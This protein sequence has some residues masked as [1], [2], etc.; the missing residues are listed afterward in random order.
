MKEQPPKMIRRIIHFVLMLFINSILLIFKKINVTF[1]FLSKRN[2]R[3]KRNFKIFL[4]D[5]KQKL[6]EY[7]KLKQELKN[8]YGEEWDEADD[9]YEGEDGTMKFKW[10]FDKTGLIIE[11][12]TSGS[13]FPLPESPFTI[14]S[15]TA[16]SLR[17]ETSD[18][19][20]ETFNRVK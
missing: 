5:Y 13:Y 8:T 16:T 1:K 11:Y 14:L 17:W 9:I 20:M 19:S 10:H 7:I 18:H 3:F 15:L 12:K 6:T 4:E 2:G